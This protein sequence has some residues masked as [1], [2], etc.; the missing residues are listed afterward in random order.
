M[1]HI[2]SIPQLDA[3]SAT[4]FEIAYS[5]RTPHDTILTIAVPGDVVRVVAVN[6]ALTDGT[7]LATRL[8]REKRAGAALTV[9]DLGFLEVPVRLAVTIRAAIPVRHTQASI[10]VETEDASATVAVPLAAGAKF[11]PAR[12]RM[13]F[14]HGEPTPGSAAE[15][16][17]NLINDGTAVA[18][19]GY[20]QL[21]PPAWA[22]VAAEG[23]WHEL[24]QEH[25]PLVV[26]PLT[27]I[28][29]GARSTYR[30][31]V[32]LAP[33]VADGTPLQ[34]DAWVALDGA[35]FPL[36]P[37]T[38]AVR[39]TAK[40]VASVKLSEARAYRYGERVAAIVV[41]RGRGSDVTRSVRVSIESE[42][43]AWDGAPHGDPLVVDFGDVPPMTD[44]ARLIEG[45][46]I[47]TPARAQ[48]R[49][50]RL[51]GESASGALDVKGCEISVTGAPRIIAHLDVVEQTAGRAYEVRFVLRND[52]D[53][54]ASSIVVCAQPHANIVGVVDSLVIDGQSRYSLDGSVVVERAG[55]EV[56]PLA[57]L[58]QRE[59]RWKVR[60][61]VEQEAA[62]AVDVTIDGETH[63]IAAPRRRYAAGLREDELAPVASGRVLPADESI[64]GPHDPDAVPSSPE[65]GMFAAAGA[66]A[67]A[68][69]NAQ[70]APASS[71][72]VADEAPSAQFEVGLTTISRWKAWFGEDGPNGD[73]ELGRYVLAAREFLPI[74]AVGG[75]QEALLAGLRTESSAVVIARLLSWKTTGTIGASGYDFATPNL[76]TCV[77]SFWSAIGSPQGDLAGVRLDQAIVALTAAQGTPFATE[78]AA[79]RDALLAAL[80]D[81]AS[82][83]AYGNAA[84]DVASAAS[85]LFEAM[86][87][88]AVPA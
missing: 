18:S 32:A 75:E 74:R 36:T 65:V 26:I 27:D 87:E 34:F 10:D 71:D 62:L 11:V 67:A 50:I 70:P 52:G 58:S 6:A 86:C 46:V 21:R 51:A 48:N 78:V 20:L 38:M 88:L 22:N 66:S 25:G 44:S 15:L 79:F 61:S 23:S 3:E 81:V 41:A 9:V 19:G 37:L 24:H 33:V 4:T 40:V 60:S 83:D 64:P 35:R 73:V 7:T 56:G 63:A 43:V 80:E 72:D 45:T 59:I 68:D 17:V 55:L 76:R 29:V 14:S 69:A 31:R 42:A 84:T 12:S 85:R 39:S 82:V 77:A 2:D 47:A 16:E 57:I 1:L 30:F 28:A 8:K 53:G 54:E 13:R 5:P 49:P